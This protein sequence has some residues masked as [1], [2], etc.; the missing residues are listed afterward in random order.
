MAK[1]TPQ[2]NNVGKAATDGSL[3]GIAMGL[4]Q[5]EQFLREVGS[6]SKIVAND[7]R[8]KLV[9]LCDD[10]KRLREIVES[11]RIDEKDTMNDTA[12]LASLERVSQECQRVLREA[13]VILKVAYLEKEK[14][15][16]AE[17]RPE[18]ELPGAEDSTLDQII[19]K[20]KELQERRILFKA[21]LDNT[22]KKLQAY[23]ADKRGEDIGK[24][25]LDKGKVKLLEIEEEAKEFLELE[26]G[27][28][29]ELQKLRWIQFRWL[30]FIVGN[31]NKNSQYSGQEMYMQISDGYMTI[32]RLISGKGNEQSVKGWGMMYLISL[33]ANKE[34]REE[35]LAQ[36]VESLVDQKNFTELVGG[37][38]ELLKNEINKLNGFFEIESEVLGEIITNAI[39]QNTL[40]A[41]IMSLTLELETKRKQG[42]PSMPSAEVIEAPVQ[43]PQAPTQIRNPDGSFEISIISPQDDPNGTNKLSFP[44]PIS[45]KVRKIGEPEK[46]TL[47]EGVMLELLWDNRPIRYSPIFNGNIEGR[48]PYDNL[49]KHINDERVVKDMVKSNIS[50]TL[51]A[52]VAINGTT[53]AKKKV[54]FFLKGD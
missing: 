53:I 19:T 41:H 13:S 10:L 29:G 24:L 20:L 9:A 52:H 2:K 23:L 40:F 49:S 37:K 26:H 46:V 5:L 54:I 27:I 39:K 44:L 6:N 43:V 47:S 36:E 7:N 21:K 22:M 31:I 50:H 32:Q 48:L 11:K 35:I 28:L 17:A 15:A 3:F 30:S 34:K 1:N 42:L 8:G 14:E 51:D 12:H 25:L 33:Y 45:I 38:Y 18:N 4:G 16:A